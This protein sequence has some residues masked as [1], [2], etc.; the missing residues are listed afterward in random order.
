MCIYLSIYICPQKHK[1]LKII[2]TTDTYKL[3]SHLIPIN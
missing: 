2:Q 1:K 3:K